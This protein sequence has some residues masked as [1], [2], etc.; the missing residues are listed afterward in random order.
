MNTNFFH[1]SGLEA[2]VALKTGHLKVTVPSPKRPIKLFSGSNTLHLVF[3]TKTEV[4]PPLIENR[5]SWSIC[6]PFFTGM[7]FCTTGAYSNASS[8]ESAS[9]YPLTGDTRYELELRP[10]GEV[11]Q[12]SASAIY[13]LQREDRALVDT[14]K[15]LVQAEGVQQNEA[16]MTFKYN[17]QSRTLS[18]ALLVPDFDVDF[19]TILRVSDESS[20]DKKSY[21]LILDVQNKKITEVA[22][23]GHVSYDQKGDGKVKGVISVPR[24]QAEARSE[25]HTHWSPTKLL[26]QMDSSA[27]AYGSTV[28]KRVAWRYDDE[29][30]E[31]DWNTGTNVDTKKAASNF[32]VD[33]SDYPRT[34]HMY[35]SSLLDHRFPH[36]DMTF[37]HIGSKLIMETSTWF[38]MA[39]RGLPYARTL[40]DQ[41]NSLSELNLQKMG[42]PDFH[43]PENLFLKSDGRVKYTLNK[44]SVKIDIPLPFGGKSS[45]DLKMFENI[46]T[47]ALNLQPMGLH[48]PSQEFQLPRFTVP[49]TYQLQVPLLGV[50]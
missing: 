1:E 39:A 38:Q 42:L 21:K 30:I 49:M 14:L 5:Q 23:V 4:I 15:F 48:L 29:K 2:R 34:L 26:L 36:T 28:S 22:L 18:S 20:N 37:R 46:R 6:K 12:Y 9:Y 35:A 19:G 40:Q 31:F 16:T 45:K 10:T 3:T 41:L 24:W 8:T 7:S 43:I 47:P 32:P 13:E 50:L 25:I 27:T 33:L 11:E 17:R 44:N